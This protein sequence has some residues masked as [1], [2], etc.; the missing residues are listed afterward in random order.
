MLYK[1]AVLDILLEIP[2]EQIN[3]FHKCNDHIII[4]GTAIALLRD[5]TTTLV[6]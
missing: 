5:K 6:L 1:V 2:Q 3:L 4:S